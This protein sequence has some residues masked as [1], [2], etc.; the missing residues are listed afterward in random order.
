MNGMIS[1]MEAKK[2]L[3]EK[4]G[5]KFKN[6]VRRIKGGERKKRKDFMHKYQYEQYYNNPYLH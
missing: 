4:F 1:K 2:D 6:A 3:D 5:R